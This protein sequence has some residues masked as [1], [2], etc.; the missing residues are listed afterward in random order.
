MTF[1]L[2]AAS[3]EQDNNKAASGTERRFVLAEDPISE[4]NGELIIRFEYRPHD[5][6]EKQTDLNAQAVEH[7]LSSLKTENRNLNTDANWLDAISA[8]APTEKDKTRS[9]LAKQLAS[10]TARNTF[11]YFIHKDLGGFLRRELDFY[12][13]NEV[14][15]LDDIEDESAPKVEQY[16]S[17]IK[18]IRNIAHKIIQFLEQLENF[19]KKLWLKKK[20]VIETNYCITL[21]R[22][23]EELYPEIAKNEAQ[24][25]EWVKLFAIDEIKKDLT[26]PGYSK[27]LKVEFLKAHSRLLLD[28]RL[29]DRAFVERLLRQLDGLDEQ[30]DGILIQS[31]NANALK[32]IATRYRGSVDCIYIDPPYNTGG[33]GFCYK[34]NYQHSS[35]MSMM[36]ERLAAMS[37]VVNDSATFFSSIDDNEA[38]RIRMLLDTEFGSDGFEAQIIVQSNKRGQTYKS[39]AKTH[40]YLFAY[41]V[42]VN[43][44]LLELPRNVEDDDSDEGGTYELWE[45]RN[46]NPK[47]GR[48]NRPNLFFPIYVDP[49][50]A[51]EDDLA[52]VAL[53]KSSRFSIEVFPRNS[54][55]E[56][57]CWRWGREKVEAE[58]TAGS[59]TVVVGRQK[60]SGDWGIYQKA[61]KEGRKAKTI[62]S[63]TSFINEKGTVEV[64]SMG[65]TE[66]GFPKPLGLLKQVVMVGCKEGGCILD[67]FAGSGT[68][69][70]AVI[71]INRESEQRRRY[72]LVEMGKHF[73]TVT[74]PRIEKAIY[75]Q[76]W[77]NGKPV[78]RVGISQF[79]KYIRLESYEDA[80]N[81]L[82][83]Q[84]TDK[85]ASLLDA[86][87]AMR[88]DYILSYM[89]DVESRGGG[90]R[91]GQIAFESR[92]VPQPRRIQA[93][94]RTQWRDTT[95]QRRSRRDLQLAPGPDRQTSRRDPWSPGRRRDR[96]EWRPRLGPVAEHR[97]DGQR[98]ARQVVREARL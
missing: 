94:S 67:C 68:T 5:G 48:F 91:L 32:H 71:D 8:F 29:F 60:T 41:G 69:A 14:M 35:W 65:L 37:P 95:R 50:S 26:G 40:E 98:R 27:P 49:N 39:I 54:E 11:D 19:Q 57:S 42:G 23:P 97:P 89:L 84:R 58:I 55:G 83:L 12:I 61:R 77:D 15:H 24:R 33:D 52:E 86:D 59:K 79:F 92:W 46:R 45:L 56:D 2:V 75:S 78:D 1:K 28:T 30:L 34:D 74:R 87:A 7:I 10:Y 51:G 44:K 96:P 82:E 76:R 9:L 17:Q 47:F 43:S 81:N 72:I 4:E 70:H 20:F 22:V 73:D 93:P 31:E 21:D 53:T 66:F 90:G 13:K 88:E 18:V 62:W 36:H 38:C 64:G 63:D 3:S 85:Q 25:E 80:L 6:K 16:L